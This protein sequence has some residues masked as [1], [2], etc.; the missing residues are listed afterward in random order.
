MFVCDFTDENENAV[1]MRYRIERTDGV[2]ITE[3]WV[4]IEEL[5]IT[6]TKL[7]AHGQMTYHLEW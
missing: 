7:P 5:M 4:T 6:T 1:P 2:V 3:D